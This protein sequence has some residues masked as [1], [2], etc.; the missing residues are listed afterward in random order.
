MAMQQEKLK[1]AG[2]WILI[3]LGI[4]LVTAFLTSQVVMPIIFAKPKDVEVP[5]LVNKNISSA[6][7]T[8]KDLGLHAIVRDSVWSDTQR[9]ENVLEQDPP[10]GTLAKLESTVYLV[11]SKGSKMVVVPSVTGLDYEEAFMTLRVSGLRAAV[12]DSTFSLNYPANAVLRS[13]PQS[14]A[15]VEKNSTVRLYLSRGPEPL[16]DSLSYEYEYEYP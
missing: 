4:I 11:I 8:L 6:K 9:I 10:P 1:K 12:V 15:K 16:P 14:G 13:L 2:Y 7:R 3:G 5:D